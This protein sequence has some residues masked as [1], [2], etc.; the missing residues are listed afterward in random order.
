MGTTNNIIEQIKAI[1]PSNLIINNKISYGSDGLPSRNCYFT[2][3][4]N[5]DLYNNTVNTVYSIYWNQLDI[6]TIAS[7]DTIVQTV[8]AELKD[9][10]NSYKLNNL[11]QTYSG[12]DEEAYRYFA[13]IST[14]KGR[15]NSAAEQIDTYSY[16]LIIENVIKPMYNSLSWYIAF[17]NNGGYNFW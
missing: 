14:L 5:I 7:Y 3:N 15:I 4:D 11:A 16:T 12:Y 10:V 13:L 8:I 2:L 1:A 9:F 6:S 17:Y